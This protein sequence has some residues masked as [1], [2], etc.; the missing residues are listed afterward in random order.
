[1]TGDII[2][3]LSPSSIAFQVTDPRQAR[4]Y[5][6]LALVGPGA[7][8]FY[9]DA[10][11]LLV[12]DP[13]LISTTHLVAHLLREI[14]SSLRDVL[15]SVGERYERLNTNKQ[16]G[17]NQHSSEI[18]AILKGLGIS[19]ADPVAQAW[20]RLPGRNSD[21]GLHARAHRDTL[22]RPRP[23]DEA[24][25]QFWD[26]MESL[27]DV[28]L[29]RFEARYLDTHRLIDELLAK[30][31]PTATDAR[32]LRNHAPNNLVALGYF[33]DNLTSTAW[34]E[35]LRDEGF[36]QHPP[37]QVVDHEQGTVWFP[38]WPASRYL[39]RIAAKAPETVLEIVRRIPHTTNAR[40]LAD[41]LDIVLALPVDLAI[42]LVPK[43][44]TWFATPHQL[45]QPER[46]FTLLTRMLHDGRIDV[47]L[48]MLRVMLAVLPNPHA[49]H[50]TTTEAL[51]SGIT[52]LRSYLDHWTYTQIIQSFAPRL[53]DAAGEE[54]L[55]LLADI[56]QDAL[57]LLC[58]NGEMDDGLSISRRAVEDHAQ[59]HP[60]DLQDI[61]ELLVSAVRD[62]AAELMPARG[63][64]VLFLIEARPYVVFRR[65][66]LHLRRLWPNVDPD[67][68]ARLVTSSVIMH[69]ERLHHEFFLLVQAVFHLLSPEMQQ[70]YLNLVDQGPLLAEHSSAGPR[71][72][73][74][75]TEIASVIRFWQYLWLLPIETHLDQQWRQRFDALQVEFGPQEH[76]DFRFYMGNLEE[77]M[78]DTEEVPDLS[79]MSIAEVVTYLTSW[80]PSQDPEQRMPQGLV[81]ALQ[82]AIVVAPQRFAAEADQFRE[83]DPVF[84][85]ALLNALHESAAQEVVFTWAPVLALCQWVTN[86][87]EVPQVGRGDAAGRDR[88]RIWRLRTI[89][90]LLTG[91][92]QTGVREIPIELRS[93]AWDVLEPLTDD[94]DPSPAYEAGTSIDVINMV[95]NTVRSAAMS[96]VIYYALWVRRQYERLDQRFDQGVQGFDHMPEVRRVLNRHLDP[97]RESS[98]AV[99][100][101]YGKW[102][103]EL[104]YLDPNWVRQNR[105]RIF[106][107]D[108]QQYRLCAVAWG[109][110]MSLN[111]VN[112]NTFALLEQ[113]YQTAVE[114]LNNDSVELTFQLDPAHRLA[115]HLMV[116][117]WW[118][119]IGIDA[120]HGLVARFFQIAP[121]DLRGHALAFL[122]RSL[123]NVKEGI[124]QDVLGQLQ[125]LWDWRMSEAKAV[126]APDLYDN[127]IAAFGWWFISERLDNTWALEQLLEALL[128]AQSIDPV[129]QVMK[130]LAEV[131]SIDPLLTVMCLGLILKVAHDRWL[132]D[133]WQE[134]I[135]GIL[136]T[137]LQSG[138]ESAVQEAMTLINRLGARGLLAYRDLLP[139]N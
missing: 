46:I 93:L 62:T 133:Y 58:D 61:P 126:P 1:V 86:R 98:L 120:P 110:Y 79:A 85:Y 55:N 106:P 90:C 30:S 122:G 117:Y 102:L 130:R 91:G 33:F 96:T 64:V 101:V 34:L 65:I 73:A 70:V 80:Q 48:Q 44:E 111:G 92:F 41:L 132:I 136:R 53:V 20:L 39:V 115:E 49:N 123:K 60:R 75:Q 4:I 83:T 66:G 87:A 139:K 129:R 38:P 128:V 104:V 11:R 89:T 138:N 131:A 50:V 5:R 77:A 116:L 134:H 97:E 56:L 13:P 32:R 112:R 108:D 8:S 40:V 68:T 42:V 109:S 71:D 19:D 103:P 88:D 54:A 37:D 43:M 51:F 95:S 118:G 36:F 81:S 29:D 84:L 17:A 52:R 6:R 26:E 35:P 3:K 107:G 31:A 16:S 24:F 74:Q 76:P 9:L 23:I 137:A 2:V 121:A 15:E 45:F 113:E 27:L 72:A 12:L 69:D 18:Q 67:G 59:N 22:G 114:R 125:E 28:I 10:C 21:Y 100:A 7:A 57:S 47:V 127:E 25:H 94:K 105:E 119:A 78:G 14:E 82:Q 63:E 124:G 99:R 135:R